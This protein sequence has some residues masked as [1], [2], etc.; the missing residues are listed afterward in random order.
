[1]YISTSSL[2]SLASEPIRNALSVGQIH[3]SCH[4]PYPEDA[5]IALTVDQNKS[6]ITD[7]NESVNY[8]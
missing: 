5:G 3:L 6:R 7:V 4:D 8:F 1:M 2:K